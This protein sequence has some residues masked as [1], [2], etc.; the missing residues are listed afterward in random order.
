MPCCLGGGGGGCSFYNP[1]YET[2]VAPLPSLGSPAFSECCWGYYRAQRFAGDF[3]D[4]RVAEIQVSDFAAASASPHLE[5]Q[6]RFVAAA[7]FR[8]PFS[9][10]AHRSLL[11]MRGDGA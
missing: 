8:Q 11:E 5:Q 3:A 7:D 6:K 1:G 2:R 4:W 9:V 10:D